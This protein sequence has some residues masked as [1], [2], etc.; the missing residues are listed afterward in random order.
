MLQDVLLN[1]ACGFF[2]TMNPPVKGYSGRQELPENL[3]ALF[4]SCA[5]IRP[6]LAPHAEPSSPATAR[7]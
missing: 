2:I 7:R 6:D 5:M 1:P 3:K 4:R